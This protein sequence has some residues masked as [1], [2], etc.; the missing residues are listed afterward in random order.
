MQRPQKENTTLRHFRL[1]LTI[2]MPA[3]L[4]TPSTN[5]ATRSRP[6]DANHDDTSN[7]IFPS[8]RLFSVCFLLYHTVALIRSNSP[9]DVHFHRRVFLSTS[10]LSYHNIKLRT[11]S[12]HLKTV[13]ASGLTCAWRGCHIFLS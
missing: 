5:A 7:Y 13:Q 6:C 10:L 8:K 9:Q 3:Y 2:C 11:K 1:P 12:A 4:L